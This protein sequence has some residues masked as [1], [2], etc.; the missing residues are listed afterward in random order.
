MKKKWLIVFHFI[1]KLNDL[2]VL[3]EWKSCIQN[4]LLLY[5]VLASTGWSGRSSMLMR[6][7]PYSSLL[8]SGNTVFCGRH[9]MILLK[10][11]L[12]IVSSTSI[13]APLEYLFKLLFQEDTHTQKKKME[14]KITLF[15]L[16]SHCL[17]QQKSNKH[18]LIS[19]RNH[20]WVGQHLSTHVR[21]GQFR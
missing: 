18:I 16:Q 2:F 17:L 12:Q 19:H 9:T 7:L 13:F 4:I 14:G 10:C 15:L 6:S 20:W 1:V 21:G 5:T 3:N 11:P 8:L